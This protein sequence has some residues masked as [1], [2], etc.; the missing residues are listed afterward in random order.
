MIQLGLKTNPE[1]VTPA[2]SRGPATF[3]DTEEPGPRLKAGVTIRVTF[4]SRGQM[5]TQRLSAPG[6]H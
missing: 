3:N 5:T 1:P 4:G 2:L 6:G